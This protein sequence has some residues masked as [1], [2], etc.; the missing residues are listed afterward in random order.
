M[1]NPIKKLAGETAV[2]GLSSILGR[3]L[4]YLLVI[5]H[6]KVFVPDAYGIVTELYSYVAILMVLFTF[7]METTYFRFTTRDK[8]PD[9]YK[10]A[11]SWI[12]VVSFISAGMI[13]LNAANIESWL[14]IENSATYIQWLAIILFLDAF[15]AIPFAKLRIEN[16]PFK[17]ALAKLT[18]IFITIGLNVFFLTILPDIVNGQL[19][20]GLQSVAQKFYDPG[21]GIGYIFLA[22]LIGSAAVYLVLIK[23]VLQTRM[24]FDIKKLSPMLIYAIPILITGLAGMLNE[25]LDKVLF[26]NLLPNEFYPG[27]SSQDALGIYGAAFKLSIFM[28]LGIQAFRYAAEP[29]FFS[30]SQDQNSKT[31]FA[32]V[33]HYFVLVCLVILVLVSLNVELIGKIFLQKPEY[34]EALYIVPVLLIGKLLFGI[35]VNISIW[36][37]ITDKTIYGTYFSIAGVIATFFSNIL[38]VPWL[39]YMGA[40]IASIVCYLLMTLLC[41]SYGQRIYP[42]PYHFTPLIIHFTIAVAIVTILFLLQLPWYLNLGASLVYSLF[43]YF[44]ELRKYPGESI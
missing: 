5:I 11:S 33:L 4:N 12:L 32:R 22:N 17:F 31:L 7:G 36:F 6:T 19:M 30:Q 3:I 20:T 28:M 43:I 29:F 23:E 40:A 44:I 15:M 1:K 24:N 34:W 2:Y 8:D 18:M 37:K 42:I 14:S 35:Y 16:R 26:R 38:L 21:L 13:Y 27:R 9:I 41:Y 39:G 10:I 25:N